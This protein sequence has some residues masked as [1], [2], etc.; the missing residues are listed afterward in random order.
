MDPIHGTEKELAELRDYMAAQMR[1]L[2]PHRSTAAYALEFLQTE[3][4]N[5]E[6]ARNQ[7]NLQ[8]AASRLTQAIAYVKDS[9]EW[10]DQAVRRLSE[11]A[12]NHA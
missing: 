3:R 9:A 7:L 10:F 2:L 4:A 6:Q 1:G 5:A 11:A 8:L 12:A